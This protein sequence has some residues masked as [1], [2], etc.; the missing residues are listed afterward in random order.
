MLTLP[1]LTVAADGYSIQPA[2]RAPSASRNVVTCASTRVGVRPAG[3]AHARL[4]FAWLTSSGSVNTEHASPTPTC[5]CH[6]QSLTTVTGAVSE[7]G[8]GG[9]SAGGYSTMALLTSAPICVE[10]VQPLG[11]RT[12]YRSSVVSAIHTRPCALST[13]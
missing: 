6:S 7:N 12:M 4:P 13:Q 3:S 2:P 11:R 9:F 10:H 5:P 1:S 8:A